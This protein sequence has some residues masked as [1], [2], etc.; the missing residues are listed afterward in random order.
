MGEYNEYLNSGLRSVNGIVNQIIAKRKYPGNHHLSFLIVE[1]ETDKKLY[2]AYIDT[3]KCQVTIADGRD[4]AEEVLSLIEKEAFIGVLAIVDA[5]FDILEGR[6]PPVQNLLLTDTHDLETMII[7]SPALDKVL[8][9]FGSTKKIAELVKRAG[10]DIRLILIECGAPIGYLRWVSLRADLSLSFE[11]LDFNKFVDKDA[12]TV[13][14]LKLIKA[15]KERAYN[16]AVD[17]SQKRTI[18]EHDAQKSM[19]LLKS[20]SHDPWHVCCGHDLVHIL[21]VGLQKAIGTHGAQTAS[22]ELVEKWL[23]LAFE[24]AHF[25]KTQLY[26][27]IQ[28]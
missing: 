18:M 13:D 3:D 5:D 27:S 11:D 4:N 24:H 9:E 25:R 17:K 16:T 12:L 2:E 22:A 28:I 21:A 10:K 19:D 26:S 20:D 7:K 8:A 1:G 14:V 23:R 6:P 15:V